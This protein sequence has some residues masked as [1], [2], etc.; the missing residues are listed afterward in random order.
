M[1]RKLFT[2]VLALCLLLVVS[3]PVS[4]D[5]I[6]IGGYED[7]VIETSA[8]L[9]DVPAS[10]D[11]S[12]TQLPTHGTVEFKKPNHLYYTP[13]PNYFGSDSFAVHLRIVFES[14]DTPPDEWDGSYPITVYPVNDYPV[15]APLTVSTFRNTPLPV[16]LFGADPVEG[17]PVTYEIWTGPAHGIL[18]D[19]S[20]P[21]GI[22][23]KSDQNIVYTPN[24][25]FIGTDSFA[26]VVFDGVDYS[27][28]ATVSVTVTESTVHIL[29]QDTP[30]N[31]IGSTLDLIVTEGQTVQTKAK[32]FVE[33]IVMSSPVSIQLK[34]GYTDD[35]FSTRT[36]TS[37]SVISGYLKI[38]QGTL[39][40]ERLVVR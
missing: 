13:F 19:S 10:Y 37:F 2:P 16:T 6:P 32:T 38:Q 14:P 5:E 28:E 21:D 1:I 22:V 33:N 29:G 25:D 11:L 20:A 12:F 34:G 30:Y 9:Y 31:E 23:L 8:I 7:V 4:A 24:Q 39:K 36:S 35:G 3:L 26:Y 15:A 27:Y 40:V 18:T 17:S